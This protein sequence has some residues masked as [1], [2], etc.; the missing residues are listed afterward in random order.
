MNFIRERSFAL[1]G[2][3]VQIDYDYYFDAYFS[4][5]VPSPPL[6]ISINLVRSISQPHQH[7]Y[8]YICGVILC[9][10]FRAHMLSHFISSYLSHFYGISICTWACVCC[11]SHV[12]AQSVFP[13]M[14]FLS[15]NKLLMIDRSNSS[16]AQMGRWCLNI[17]PQ[18]Q[19]MQAHTST[20]FEF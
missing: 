12:A 1:Y 17:E 19:R 15:A 20:L 2:L 8:P 6:R 5:D 13:N 7:F 4:C 3:L 14:W 16:T 10:I 11:T 18:T 9:Q